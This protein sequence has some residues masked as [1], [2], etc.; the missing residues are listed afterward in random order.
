MSPEEEQPKGARPTNRRA[1]LRRFLVLTGTLVALAMGIYLGGANL[2]LRSPSLHGKIFKSPEK[3]RVT[4]ESAWTLWPGRVHLHGV[5]IRGQ[6]RE[7]QWWARLERTTVSVDLPALAS[8]T[9]HAR[10][11]GGGGLT[12]RLRQRLTPGEDPPRGPDGEPLAPEIPGL[13]NP[14]NPPPES[15]ARNAPGRPASRPQGWRIRLEGIDLD[16]LGEIWIDRYRMAGAGRIGGDLDFQVRGDLEAR[17][18][19]FEITDARLLAGPEE[20]L[21]RLDLGLHV[22]LDPFHPKEQ[23]G[24]A[25]LGFVSGDLRLDTRTRSLGFLD[26][27]ITRVPGLRLDGGGGLK[28]DVTLERGELAAGS[29]IELVPDGLEITYQDFVAT[30]TG[31]L[32]GEVEVDRHTRLSARFQ[33]F[34]L[35]L[36]ADAG[37]TVLEGRG[38]SLT[39]QADEL[40]LDRI[41]PPPRVEIELTELAI[42]DLQDLHKLLPADVAG[43][44]LRA[45]RG[46]LAARGVLDAE[47]GSGRGQVTLTTR[48]LDARLEPAPELE[49]E[50]QGDLEVH[51]EIPRFDL[52]ERS[53]ETAGGRLG[54]RGVELRGSTR[55]TTWKTVLDRL[56]LEVDPEGFRQRT[57]HASAISGEG[58]TVEVD[59][60]SPEASSE[61]HGRRRRQGRSTEPGWHLELDRLDLQ[62][63]RA[64][65]WNEHEIRGNGRLMASL[66]WQLGGTLAAERLMWEIK[67][68]KVLEHRSKPA[69]PAAAGPAD[70]SDPAILLPSLDLRAEIELE[71]FL[72][73]LA[74]RSFPAHAS[75]TVHLTAHSESLALLDR[76]VSQVPE[77]HLGGRGDLDVDLVLQR[78]TLVPGTRLTSIGDFDLTFLDYQAQGSGRLT[79]TIEAHGKRPIRSSVLQAELD[80]FDLSWKNGPRRYV[81]GEGLQ[82]TVTGPEI[83][84]GG[85]VEMPHVQLRI[86]LPESEVPDV[87]VYNSL[88]PAASGLR[89]TS[90][91]GYLSGHL[92]YDTETDLGRADLTLRA[93]S[94]GARHESTDLTG[95]FRLTTHIPEL[96]L[97]ERLFHLDDTRLD[98]RRAGLADQPMEAGWWMVVEMPQSLLRLGAEPGLQGRIRASM[99]DSSPLT[100]YLVSRKRA[101]RW[102]DGALTLEDVDLAADFQGRPGLYG[103][104][105][106]EIT[107][108]NLEIL[109]EMRIGEREH[110][111]LFHLKAGPLSVG[112]EML[113][114]K[115]DLKILHS[116]Q[117]FEQRKRLW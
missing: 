24:L 77:L 9:F 34:E 29:R 88:L 78:G 94:L 107:G 46:A 100:A 7:I 55:D 26:P 90:G 79:G 53:F 75:G 27:W 102:I 19:R 73:G 58:V 3:L 83:Y 49:L 117:W 108:H 63:I 71:P 69:G 60:A 95:D 116:R 32:A 80:R 68:G 114:G 67:D 81:R 11:I 14:P 91:R 2:F 15:L 98:I 89:L 25:F 74:G 96:R 85:P 51:V 115:K 47:T 106:I 72:P 105:D 10:R 1:R 36:E 113:D 65:R 5:E 103:I 20:L 35:S 44:R 70:A 33:R 57:V 110:S 13:E 76:F 86:D 22:S 112:F 109:G 61:R 37:P 12:F 97:R 45:G 17:D 101:L 8:R 6:N 28:V 93:S 41:P 16:N 99:R 66:D 50:L 62:N 59:R 31:E 111:G 104:R 54:L 39:A 92:E 56:D 52:V 87:T 30:G 64:L 42:P 84:L 18:V 4:W 43:L 21:E 38:L 82:L 23:K 40:H 48:G